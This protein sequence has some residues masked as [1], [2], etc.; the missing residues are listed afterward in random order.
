MID[1]YKVAAALNEVT[2][3]AGVVLGV[4]VFVTSDDVLYVN[5][6]SSLPHSEEVKFKQAI[7]ELVRGFFAPDSAM[8]PLS[9]NTTQS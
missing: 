9:N 7:A 5:A 3:D 6:T 8:L 4:V 2:R 1:T